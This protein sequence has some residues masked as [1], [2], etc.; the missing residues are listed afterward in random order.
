MT[1]LEQQLWQWH[2]GHY[3]DDV[4]IPAT[5]RKLVEEVGELGEALMNKTADKAR[6]EAGDVGVLLLIVLR[7]MGYKSLH[8][9]MEAA[10]NK[11]EKAAWQAEHQPGKAA[12]AQEGK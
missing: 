8:R 4:D 5:Y 6:M 3:G 2:V 1:N 7:G 9:A 12:Q 10:Y 11:I